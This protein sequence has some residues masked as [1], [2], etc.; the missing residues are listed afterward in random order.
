M[1]EPL[2]ERSE[3]IV[4]PDVHAFPG[5][6]ACDSASRSQIAV[7]LVVAGRAIGVLDV[8]SPQPD[9]FAEAD[10]TFLEAITTLDIASSDRR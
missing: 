1:T 6:I 8:A 2:E 5:H 4:V 7:P 10:R 3:T 9:R